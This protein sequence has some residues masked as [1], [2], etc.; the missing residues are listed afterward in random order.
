MKLMDWLSS[1]SP[2]TVEEGDMGSCMHQVMS[3]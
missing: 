2:V 1:S 3:M